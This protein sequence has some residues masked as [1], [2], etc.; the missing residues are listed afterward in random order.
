MPVSVTASGRVRRIRLVDMAGG[1]VR[2][3]RTPVTL[4]L[5][6]SPVYV[7]LEAG[8]PRPM[9]GSRARQ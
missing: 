7:V 5:G 1:G 2:D 9:S 3:H 8:A 6:P 4:A